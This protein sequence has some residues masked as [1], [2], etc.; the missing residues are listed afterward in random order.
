MEALR[1]LVAIANSG[2]DL[3]VLTSRE[4][5]REQER[6]RDPTVR[7]LLEQSRPAV[8]LVREDHLRVG[9]HY[10]ES[11]RGFIGYFALTEVV[12]EGL[13]D[14][15]KGAGLKPPDARHLMYAVHNGCDWFTTLDPD[16]FDRRNKLEAM[17]R[18]L[19]IVNPSELL[20]ELRRA[21]AG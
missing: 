2:T 10:Q 1:R 12:D 19:R 15:L 21:P 8:P 17:C 5:W 18:G 6:A 14:A 9:F 7:A 20:A 16:F 11:E 3:Q 4:S 13:L